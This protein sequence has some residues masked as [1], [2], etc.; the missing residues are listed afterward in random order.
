MH[1]TAPVFCR[2]ILPAC[3]GFLCSRWGACC[4]SGSCSEMGS[5]LAF[6]CCSSQRSRSETIPVIFVCELS[7]GLAGTKAIV[8][9]RT[10]RML[11]PSRSAASRSL[12]NPARD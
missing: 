2:F 4:G 7:R 6:A 8:D 9:V 12:S 3:C 10:V 5:G 1:T 11:V